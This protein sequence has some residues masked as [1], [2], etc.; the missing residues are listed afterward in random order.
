MGNIC[1]V[2]KL[3]KTEDEMATSPRTHKKVKVCL[4]CWDKHYARL[5]K[6]S[7]HH[8]AK[9]RKEDSNGRK[10]AI[11][12]N[13][14]FIASILCGA[15][16]MDCGYDNWIALELDHRDAAEKED[17]VTRLVN[18][19]ISLER[20]KA[21]AAKCDIVCANCHAIRTAIQAKSWRIAFNRPD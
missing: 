7:E 19:G 13:R 16:C 17:A 21:E 10:V 8:K 15:K 12:R 3:D 4:A 9:Q 18:N 14:S 1:S 5:T 2:C 11:A 20:V 6:S